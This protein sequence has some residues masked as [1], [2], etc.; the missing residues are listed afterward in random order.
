[1]P[2]DVYELVDS[3]QN[4]DGELIDIYEHRETGEEIEVPVDTDV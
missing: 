4:D 3:Y 2:G 1:M